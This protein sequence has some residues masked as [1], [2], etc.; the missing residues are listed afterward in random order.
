MRINTRSILHNITSLRNIAPALMVMSALSAAALPLEQYSTSSKLSEGRWRKVIVSTTGMQFLSNTQLKS[1]GFSNPS[2]VNVYGYGGREVNTKLSTDTYVDDLP[3]LPVVRTSDGIIFFGVNTVTWTYNGKTVPYLS[4]Q[5]SY[6]TQSIYFVSD[7][8]TE[9]REITALDAPPQAGA[10]DKDTFVERL[11]HEQELYA[12]SNTGSWMFGEDFTSNRQQEF[13][14][15]L[16]GLVGNEA[17]VLFTIAAKTT[18]ASSSFSFTA[19]GTQLEATNTDVITSTSSSEM[20]T[21]YNSS[22]KH[23][24]NATEDLSLGIK[25]TPGGVVYHARLDFIDISY[26]RK[27]ELDN[28]SLYFYQYVSSSNTVAYNIA[29]CSATTQ[30]WDVT[31]PWNPQK[32]NYT[33]EGSTARFTPSGIG[34]HEY[35]AFEPSK[36]TLAPTASTNVANQDIHALATPDMVIISPS[37][38]S[39]QAERVAEM[40]RD[41][42]GMTVYVL[43]PEEIYNEF[44]SGAPDVMAFRKAMKMWYDRGMNEDSSSS[45]FKYCLLFGR[46]T[47]DNRMI[48]DAVKKSGYPRTLIW[49]SPTGTTQNSSYSTD[50]YLMILDDNTSIDDT[51]SGSMRISVGRFPV[52]YADDCKQV[53]DKLLSYLESDDFGSWRNKVMLIADD[54]DNGVHLEQIERFYSRAQESGNGGDHRY[55][56]LYLD[57]YPMELT[58]TGESYPKAK[59]RMSQ[60]MQEGVATAVYVGH[61]NAKEWTHESFLTYSEI[62]GFSNKRTPLFYTATCEFSRWDDDDISGGEIMWSN[63]TAGAI[64]M[65]STSRSVYIAQNGVL[66]GYMG[67]YMFSKDDD[68]KPLR[69][70]DIMRLGKDKYRGDDNK[71]RY[72]LIGDPAMRLPSPQ[73]KVVVETLNGIDMTSENHPLPE[74]TANSQVDVTGYI[75]DEQGNLIHNFN[76]VLEPSLYDAQKVVTTYG[77]GDTGKEMYYN[78]NTNLLFTS[79]VNI[80]KGRWATKLIVPSEIDNL[81]N[82][83]LL[84]LYA[85][86]DK[87]L[88]ANGHTDEFYIY[89]WNSSA[90]EDTKGPELTLF[91]LNNEKFKDGDTVSASPI[92]YAKMSDESGI[93]IST[94][95]IGHQITLTL[96]GKKYY[97]DVTNYYTPTPGDIYSGSIAYP[98]SS[99]EVGEHELTLTVWDNANNHTEASLRFNVS[100]A[101]KPYINDITTDVNPATTSV[102]F[103]ILH[104]RVQE[105]TEANVD[106]FDLSGMKVWSGSFSGSPDFQYGS[107]VTWNLTDSAGRRVPRGIYLYRA[108]LI[109]SDGF[110]ISET[111]KLAVTAQ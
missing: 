5:N 8:D 1:M 96:D 83:A 32:I 64:A 22:Y 34:Y 91:A 56:K 50:D 39:T 62:L 71:L 109:T 104:D 77:N 41:K 13:Q 99:V 67:D 86:S 30:I 82:P 97:E 85:Y 44:S 9:E 46:P 7:R 61:A 107:N 87:G 24:T 81:Y 29:G 102:T 16:K 90:A 2:K 88:E 92:V 95:G 70:G 69:I 36:I 65:L 31:K 52:R 94:T 58:A 19:N 110:E 38:F 17:D 60:L 43:T 75:A 72:V 68:G 100:A 40:H 106:V 33:L 79:K 103:S 12:P 18:S 49:Q 21:R 111:K 20:F 101:P 59:E 84:S 63:P 93:N 15:N 11:L 45:K 25:Y 3:Q 98:L 47:Y 28:G 53:V 66:T 48:T 6:S 55:E 54:Q 80:S 10:E 27:M 74:L 35:I 42:D 73:Y 57:S 78:D 51:A 4:S 37:E 14:F 105:D 76:G 89:G 26:K 108:T 23:I